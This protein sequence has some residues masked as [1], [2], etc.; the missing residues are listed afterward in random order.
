[1]KTLDDYDAKYTIW[2]K[3]PRVRPLPRFT[4]MPEFG[5]QKFS[6]YEELN[7]WKAELLEEIARRGGLRWTK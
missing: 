4:G 6:S 1:M 3:A 5:A 7:R 2:A